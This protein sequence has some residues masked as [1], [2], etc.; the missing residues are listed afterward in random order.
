MWWSRVSFVS[1]S[2]VCLT[3]CDPDDPARPG[4]DGGG[5]LGTFDAGMPLDAA[6]PPRDA[7][8]RTDAGDVCGDGMR[9]I[10]EACDDGDADPGD[11]CSETC[12]VEEGFR[13]PPAGGACRAIVCGDRRVESPERCDDGDAD[14][15]DGC[16]ASCQVEDGWACTIPGLECQAASCGDGIVA[17]FEQCDDGGAATA[18]CSAEC[19][20]EPGYHCPTPGAACAP[21]RCGD[22]MRQGVEQCDD[23]NVR[24]Y[25]G[26]DNECRNEPSCMGG[27]CAATC[28]DGVILPGTAEDC[29][30]GN[31]LSGDGCSA[32]CDEEDGFECSLVEQPLPPSIRL[33]V[34]H[35]DFR[36]GDQAGSPT[37]P[38]FNTRGGD[39]ITFDMVS[40]TLDAER[41]PVFSGLVVGGSG[42]LSTESFHDWYRDSARNTPVLSTIELTRVGTTDQYEFAS[43][44]FFPLDGQGWD[45]PTSTAP[46]TYMEDHNYGFTTEIR[47]WFQYQ[48]DERL[49]FRGDDDVW[50][51][52]DGHLCLDVGG[53]HPAVPAVM[54]FANPANAG[55]ARQ[56]AIVTECRDRLTVGGVYEV[57]VFHAER[58]CCASNFRLTLS[59]FVTR[60]SRCDW[61]CG[62]GIVTR[63]ELCDDGPGM[64]TGEYGRCG[65]DCRSRGPYCGDGA[66]ESGVE[67]CDE[68]PDNDGRYGGCN[69]DCTA[70]PRCGD[71]VRQG[72]EECDAGEENGAPTSGC[73]AECELTLV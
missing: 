50:V 48:G 25:D 49:D 22:G 64:N 57:I 56:T 31:T 40:D 30:D 52:V 15:G 11:G 38:D 60:E 47:Y 18:G 33:P 61:T 72:A 10:T 62:D 53:L 20:L 37:H 59:G 34:V 5:A 12:V 43:T 16:D 6:V 41:R 3:A 2:F 21:T 17:G 63:Y 39:G 26:C 8:P 14:A 28:G 67:Q 42:A 29:D 19:R 69:P 23:G 46:E 4:P 45:S 36:G 32:T 44:A 24:A 65:A 51:F 55:D 70:G 13:C 1:L 35:R 68:G 58:R 66:V 9:G 71:G 54:D 27:T 7:L 73:D